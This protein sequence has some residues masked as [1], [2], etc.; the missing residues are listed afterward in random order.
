MLA[1]QGDHASSWSIFCPF[2]F[3]S[4]YIFHISLP[5]AH[6]FHKIS[7]L[8]MLIDFVRDS[9]SISGKLSPCLLFRLVWTFRYDREEWIHRFYGISAVGSENFK[10]SELRQSDTPKYTAIS[11]SHA[12][13]CCGERKCFQQGIFLHFASNWISTFEMFDFQKINTRQQFLIWLIKLS[14][15]HLKILTLK[16]DLH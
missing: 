14:N 6:N 10:F 11:M 16:M 9:K 2:T 5:K 12:L 7:S 15:F 1:I 4:L 3:F 13:L 8:E